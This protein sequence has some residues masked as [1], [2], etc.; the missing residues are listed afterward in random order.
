[1]D[2]TLSLKKV[3]HFLF[4]ED[5]V[6]SWIVNLVLA[7]VL[8]KFIIY[9][10]LSLLLGTSLPLVAVVSGSMEHNGLDFDSW[11]E[12]NKEYYE[13]QGIS[14]EMFSSYRFTN[15][16]DKGD[17]MILVGAESVVLGDVIVYSSATH[18][19]PIIHR[20]IYIDEETLEYELKGDN[21]LGAD[22]LLVSDSQV[23]GKALYRIPK[24][25]WVKIWFAE[26]I[27]G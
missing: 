1:M 19:Y 15:G 2:I 13:A 14:Q 26:L 20:V 24:I 17:V 8:V 7:F 18:Q 22:P 4:K 21:N 25:G 27:G 6:L 11:W 16:F 23:L 9:P 3:Y 10:G 5:S 12:E